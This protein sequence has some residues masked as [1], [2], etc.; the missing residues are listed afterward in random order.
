M[1]IGNKVGFSVGPLYCG[2]VALWVG[3]WALHLGVRDRRP[4]WGYKHEIIDGDSIKTFG[5]GRLML[6]VW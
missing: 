5:L 3:T 4:Q 1:V 6:L 2:V